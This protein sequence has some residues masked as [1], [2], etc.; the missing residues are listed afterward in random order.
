MLQLE[1]S[2]TQ[3]FGVTYKCSPIFLVGPVDQCWPF[4]IESP[5]SNKRACF[6]VNA[7]VEVQSFDLELITARVN[8]GTLPSMK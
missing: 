4:S 6:P 3:R 5:A 1:K 7:D 8:A 2:S